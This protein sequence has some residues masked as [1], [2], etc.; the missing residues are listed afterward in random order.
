M[1]G[2]DLMHAAENLKDLPEKTDEM[3]ELLRSIESSLTQIAESIGK[4]VS[5]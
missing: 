2:T 1:L 3:L 5:E 4:V